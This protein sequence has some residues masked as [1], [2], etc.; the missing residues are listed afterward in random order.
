MHA[1]ELRW[2]NVDTV[3]SRYADVLVLV[4]RSTDTPVIA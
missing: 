2:E 4:R 1:D 3:E